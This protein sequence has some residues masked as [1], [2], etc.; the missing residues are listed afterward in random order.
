[1]LWIER[2]INKLCKRTTRKNLQISWLSSCITFWQI[3]FKNALRFI[4]LW[5]RDMKILNRKKV[6][7]PIR[8]TK[9]RIR[10]AS[11]LNKRIIFQLRKKLETPW[12]MRKN[13]IPEFLNWMKFKEER[14]SL[15]RI[16]EFW[17]KSL[18][19][20]WKNILF[21]SNPGEKRYCL[22]AIHFKL[23]LKKFLNLFLSSASERNLSEFRHRIKLKLS[24]SRQI[25]SSYLLIYM[26]KDWRILLA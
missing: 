5:L 9:K 23:Q 11:A 12:W 10:I 17:K 4:L 18:K 22:E 3:F 16:T 15:K 19:K 6:L 24:K 2:N 1:M 13:S 20:S 8:D 21:D 7:I 25:H 14:F 26:K